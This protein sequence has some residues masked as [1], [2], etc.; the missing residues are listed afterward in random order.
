MM[1]HVS[2]VATRGG[3]KESK[4]YNMSNL[5]M[6]SFKYGCHLLIGNNLEL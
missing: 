2:P 3:P 5:A 1:S 4:D 6:R